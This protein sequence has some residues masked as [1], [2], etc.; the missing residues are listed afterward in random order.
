MPN[1]D[2]HLLG[3]L[4]C[5]VVMKIECIQATAPDR[6]NLQLSVSVLREQFSL[7][8][9]MLVLL[10]DGRSPFNSYSCY[11]RIGPRTKPL[12]FCRRTMHRHFLANGFDSNS[13]LLFTIKVLT[14]NHIA[15]G[16]G[17]APKRRQA[18]TWT[19][20][21]HSVNASLGRNI[22]TSLVSTAST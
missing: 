6:G 18:I 7:S 2:I 14:I 19:M 20:G 9:T 11:Y 4:R 10:N 15:S 5:C 22:W 21:I 12:P 16:D 3:N 8:L 17:L 13:T 1:R